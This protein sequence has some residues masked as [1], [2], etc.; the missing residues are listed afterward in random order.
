MATEPIQGAPHLVTILEACASIMGVDNG[1][2]ELVFE[3]G[4]LTRWYSHSEKRQA[5]ELG[6]FDAEAVHLTD[7]NR[8]P[9]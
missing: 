4:R 3:H 8:S 1:R 5:R 7:G 6:E 2:L 9:S